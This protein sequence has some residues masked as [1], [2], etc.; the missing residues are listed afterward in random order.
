MPIQDTDLLLI[1][2]TSGVSKKIAASKLKANLAANTY[3]NY[4]LLVNK[5]DY[6]SRFVYAQNMQASV[7]PTDYMLVERGGTSYKVNGQQIID[8]FPSVP[9]GAAGAIVDVEDIT[10]DGAW[11]STRPSTSIRWQG[12]AF[13]LGM[14]VAVSRTS[15][16]IY[17]SSDDGA[18]WTKRYELSGAEWKG[19]T[20]GNG[21][22]VAVGDSGSVRAIYSDDGINWSQA[23]AQL[24]HP[25]ESVAYGNGIYV[26]IANTGGK[27]MYS[28]DGTNWIV[29]NVENYS[30]TR[31]AFGDG[32]FVCV[33]QSHGHFT[34]STTNGQSWTTTRYNPAEIYGWT[35]LAYGNGQFIAGS[36]GSNG[37][38]MRSPDGINWSVSDSGIIFNGRSGAFGGGRFVFAYGSNI[39]YS[40]NDTA[41]TWTQANVEGG[42]YQ[43]I[44]YGDGYFVAVDQG[45]STNLISRSYGGTGGLELEN[46]LTLAATD[47]LD[48]FTVGDA[49]TMV[50][51]DGAVASYTPVTSAISNVAFAPAWNQSENWT[52][53]I[54]EGFQGVAGLNDLFDGRIDFFANPDSP[55]EATFTPPTPIPCS[56]VK[57]VV[58]ND[59]RSGNTNIGNAALKINGSNVGALGPSGSGSIGVIE[60]ETNQLTSL[61]FSSG[62]TG[63]NGADV[64]AIYVDDLILVNANWSGTD[65]GLGTELSFASPN[66]DLKFFNPGDNVGLPQTTSVTFTSSSGS[67]RAGGISNYNSTYVANSQT[68]SQG[69]LGSRYLELTFNPPLVVLNEVRVNYGPDDETQRSSINGGS[70]SPSYPGKYSFT[71]NL[72]TLR[73]SNADSSRNSG[74]IQYLEIDGQ[75]LLFTGSLSTS[76]SSPQTASGVV[77]TQILVVSTDTAAN[78]MLVD[79]G[80]W[81]NGG[82]VTGPAKSGTGNFNGNAGVV[83]DVSN[84]NQEWI[85]NDNR[86]NEQFFIKAA[87]TR[88]GLAI[89]RDKAIRVAQA[90]DPAKAPYPIRSLVTYKGDYYVNAGFAVPGQSKWVDLGRIV[91]NE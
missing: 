36:A 14:F 40:T 74:R 47:N 41:T 27:A 70:Y 1:E 80:T 9:A 44:A 63:D 84:S 73:I 17:S 3:N 58:R 31:I 57:V 13:G 45:S 77:T 30:W 8:Y 78:T 19:I 4:K 62:V 82:V 46:K 26:C 33:N 51:S 11:T 55:G 20:F 91:G 81:S 52:G 69:G 43:D 24:Q 79:G 10:I 2:D 21:R 25:W 29:S 66:P 39:T 88:T 38:I 37:F 60:Y 86:L 65:P 89:L 61:Y 50:D 76:T 16:Q 6:S 18:T 85:S 32:K 64:S 68:G 59:G 28:S 23:A 87:S 48:L 35:S 22:F 90:Y 67:F 34:I 12:V 83:V 75:R 49:I 56:K 71:G 7:A 5:P 72:A 54:S 42:E 15:G 53:Y